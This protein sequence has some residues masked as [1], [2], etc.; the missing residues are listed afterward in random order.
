MTVHAMDG[1]GSRAKEV[2]T[3]AR[4]GFLSFTIG[5]THRTIYYEISG[6]DMAKSDG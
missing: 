4:E 2:K 3:A 1:A 6:G 5:G